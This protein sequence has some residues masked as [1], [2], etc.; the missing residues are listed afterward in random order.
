V[1]AAVMLLLHLFRPGSQV[2]PAEA[3]LVSSPVPTVPKS[4]AASATTQP[5]D[6]WPGFRGPGGLGIAGGTYPTQWDGS[7]G[8]NILWKRRIP[9]PGHNSPAISGGRVFLAGGTAEKRDVYCVDAA[10]GAILWSKQV[11]VG[12]PALPDSAVDAGWAPSTM[13][14]WGDRVFAIFPTGD[15]ICLDRDGNEVWRQNLGPIK[16]IYAH[17]SSLIT[18]DSLLLVQLDQGTAKENLSAML[19][20][21]CASGKSAWRTPRP[22]TVSWSTPAIV[23]GPSGS[24]LLALGDPWVV[25][26]EPKTGR[27]IWRA[28]GMA[29][30]VV[31]SPAFANGIAYAATEASQLVAFRTDGRGDI[32]TTGRKTTEADAMPDIVSPVAVGGR[33]LL[34]ASGGSVSFVDASTGKQLWTQE[35]DEGFHASPIVAGNIAYV[36]DRKGATHVIELGDSF[37]EIAKCPLGEAVEA[38][39]AFSGSRIYLRGEQDL[40]CISINAPQI[41]GQGVRP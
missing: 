12:G 19:A 34:V 40:F 2:V 11:S 21:D 37:R 13:A 41:S 31:T 18:F 9:L 27:E 38:T 24:Q 6:T 10:R 25:A 1:L 39:A 3:K 17:C 7:T 28:K 23:T 26:Y 36:T 16:N 22:V 35:F 14:V 15:L 33:V 20:F 4:D 8:K 29:G 30:E 5:A 32:T